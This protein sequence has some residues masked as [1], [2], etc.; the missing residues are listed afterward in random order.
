MNLLLLRRQ[1]NLMY[2]LVIGQAIC[3]LDGVRGHRL[4][5]Q[6]HYTTSPAMKSGSRPS[7][8]ADAKLDQYCGRVESNNQRE[9]MSKKKHGI[10]TFHALDGCSSNFLES[11]SLYGG[12]SR[13]FGTTYT[14][15]ATGVGLATSW[16]Y[17]GSFYAPSLLDPFVLIT[18]PEPGP[19]TVN[20]EVA[21]LRSFCS[22]ITPLLVPEEP[23]KLARSQD[24]SHTVPP[25][26]A[27]PNA[28]IS[29]D[30]PKS[31]ARGK[32][33]SGQGSRS[34]RSRQPKTVKRSACHS[35]KVKKVRCSCDPNSKLEEDAP[36][37]PC[38]KAG[39]PCDYS[40]PLEG[41]RAFDVVL[42]RC[43]SRV[44]ERPKPRANPR[45]KRDEIRRFVTP[46]S[47]EDFA[48]TLSPSTSNSTTSRHG[49]PF[50]GL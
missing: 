38:T 34:R 22:Q 17:G 46:A 49:T 2:A 8:I 1:N 37:I 3:L 30:R 40:P 20:S 16:D 5:T 43:Q 7:F 50:D 47:A 44:N 39:I 45:R 42:R 11:R 28:E 4:H 15:N 19:A 24:L 21:A 27:V 35:C 48:R 26:A 13:Q 33:S 41:S 9:T 6:L 31:K 18:F 29:G 12:S 25:R 32:G 10:E 23:E 14:G 36:C